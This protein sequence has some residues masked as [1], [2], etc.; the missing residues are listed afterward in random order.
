MFSPLWSSFLADSS[1]PG[2]SG[3]LL[4]ANQPLVDLREYLKCHWQ[5]Q[6]QPPYSAPCLAARFPFSTLVDDRSMFGAI[7]LENL[8]ILAFWETVPTKQRRDCQSSR[9]TPRS[10]Q[11]GQLGRI[12]SNLCEIL[13]AS[14][15]HYNSRQA[16]FGRTFQELWVHHLSEMR[17][18][19]PASRYHASLSCPRSGQLASTNALIFR[20]T[21][22]LLAILLMNSR[23]MITCLL[24]THQRVRRIPYLSRIRDCLFHSWEI[25]FAL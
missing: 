16:V 4:T 7:Y 22:S 21:D 11:T 20:A 14:M 10:G 5:P 24:T 6:V 3:R 12:G 2:H 23:L 18:L 25:P 9:Q 15:H 13:A 8:D 19:L 17:P 1:P